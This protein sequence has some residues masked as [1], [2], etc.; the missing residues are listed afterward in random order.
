MTKA[1]LA[2]S[3]AYLSASNSRKSAGFRTDEREARGVA[4][5]RLSARRRARSSRLAER[6]TRD[7]RHSPISRLADC[8]N[9]ALYSRGSG[10]LRVRDAK[11]DHGEPLSMLVLGTTRKR[12]GEREGEKA[13]DG[14]L[15]APLINVPRS[16]PASRSMRARTRTEIPGKFLNRPIN[17][18]DNPANFPSARPLLF[19][20]WLSSGDFTVRL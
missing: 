3:R 7:A 17:K 13:D 20:H 18:G 6:R 5:T 15:S 10:F 16:F 12:V 1:R 14:L 8:A 9:T 11:K 2:Q 4:S 19:S